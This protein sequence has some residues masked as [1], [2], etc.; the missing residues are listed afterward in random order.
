MLFS[1]ETVK[2][3]LSILYLILRKTEKNS[4]FFISGSALRIKKRNKVYHFLGAKVTA[5]KKIHRKTRKL[6]NYKFWKPTSCKWAKVRMKHGLVEW[7]VVLIYLQSAIFSCNCQRRNSRQQLLQNVFSVDDPISL[8]N[9]HEKF[10]WK[11]L[12]TLRFHNSHLFAL[13]TCIDRF[14]LNHLQLT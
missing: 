8:R 13:F 12:V 2:A 4:Q 7:N 5:K 3:Y 10:F 9:Y 11:F 6:G 14:K 1:L